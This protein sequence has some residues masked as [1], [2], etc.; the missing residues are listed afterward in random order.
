MNSRFREKFNYS[1]EMKL[2]LILI[3]IL[4]LLIS[5]KSD[6]DTLNELELNCLQKKFG[7]TFIFEPGQ[8]VELKEL[9]NKYFSLN[10]ISSAKKEPS[11]VPYAEV[12]YSIT[13]EDAYF[14][15]IGVYIYE[16]YINDGISFSGRIHF[17]V[18]GNVPYTMYVDD[19]EF[20]ETET[21]YIFHSLRVR[22][23]E[24]DPEYPEVYD[25]YIN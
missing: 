4:G 6:D 8:C 9:P 3:F 10:S 11:N 15:T 24:F 18:N 21:E 22:F 19:V 7:E 20:T 25:V 17:S 13:E 1:I 14:D 16:D 12:A 23:G 5:C 2:K